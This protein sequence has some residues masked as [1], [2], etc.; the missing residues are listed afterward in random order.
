MFVR[1]GSHMTTDNSPRGQTTADGAW[2]AAMTR[3]Q[4]ARYLGISAD[5]IDQLRRRGELDPVL[6]GG[7]IRGTRY[8]RADLDEY[9]STAKRRSEVPA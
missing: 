8:L 4:A 3:T 2:P 5:F 1:Y 7:S 6:V 9:L